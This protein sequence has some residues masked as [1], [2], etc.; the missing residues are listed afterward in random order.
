MEPQPGSPPSPGTSSSSSSPNSA[1]EVVAPSDEMP[2]PEEPAEVE[3]EPAG[4]KSTSSSSSSSSESSAE[5]LRDVDVVDLGD[6]S[7]AALPEPSADDGKPD[8]EATPVEKQA[9][10]PVVETAAGT[11][12]ED[13]GQSAAAPVV[14]L[15]DEQ[16]KPDDWAT[17]PEEAPPPPAIDY[18]FS[19]DGSGGPGAGA[20]PAWP[21]AEAPQQVHALPPPAPE[22]DPGRIP[23]SVFQPRTST[24]QAEWSMTSN[25]S[26][27]SIQG[28][29]DMPP[30]AAGSRSHFDFFYDEAMAA[31]EAESGNNKLPSVAE[32]TEPAAESS[33]SSREFKVPGSAGSLGGSDDNANKKAAAY[34]RHDSGS[35]GSSSNFSFAFPILAPTSPKKKELA[36]SALYQPLE[37][38]WEPQRPP[39]ATQMEPPGASAFVEMTTEAE[40]RGSTDGCCCCGCCWFDCSW[41][42]CCGWWR[43]CSCGCG[44]CSCPSFCRCSWCLCS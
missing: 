29:S 18:S 8:G 37:K 27:F 42:T 24:S 13:D 11:K 1:A 28:A 36:G 5:S 9:A 30:Y 6:T 10:P 44:C 4:R 22:F 41:A 25:E 19:S 3:Q 38:G 26:L 23:A 31:A 14:K 15:D 21:T 32:G 17:W 20:A 43:C 39:A 33:S 12:P 2:A 40:R 34:R 35:G 16:A 7:A